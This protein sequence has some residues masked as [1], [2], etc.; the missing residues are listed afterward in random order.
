MRIYT[1]LERTFLQLPVLLNKSLKEVQRHVMYELSRLSSTASDKET[2]E[3]G[4]SLNRIR[5]GLVKN[6]SEG[7]RN[8]SSRGLIY[9]LKFGEQLESGLYDM[10]Q[11]ANLASQWGLRLV[12]PF[13]HMST[14]MLPPFT[15]SYPNQNVLSFGDIYNFTAAQRNFKRCL[16]V[17][18]DVLATEDELYKAHF[19]QIVVVDIHKGRDRVDF[20]ACEESLKRHA[21]L[22]N[23]LEIF[24]IRPASD[25]SE[26][27]RGRTRKSNQ[28]FRVHPASV[29]RWQQENKVR[30]SSGLCSSKRQ[31]FQTSRR[32]HKLEWSQAILP[33]VLLH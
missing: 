9:I 11:M 3:G 22:L 25:H 13:V 18:Y 33:R 24:K 15:F 27:L 7:S 19:D 17:D 30:D 6:E 10:W 21:D 23:L 12:E 28:C 16:K 4:H 32:F 1:H 14:Y 8:L 20:D 29:C 31:T 26:H 5:D 2:A